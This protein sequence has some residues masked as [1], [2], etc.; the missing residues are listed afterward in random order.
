MRIRVRCFATLRE[1][2]AGLTELELAE[3]ATVAGAWAALADRYPA[4]EPHR[5]FAQ[6]AQNGVAVGWEEPVSDG[7][8]VA[9]LPPVSGGSEPPIIGLSAEP[10]D[11]EALERVVATTHG[12]VVTF[13]G[14]A[15]RLAD[16]GRE[17]TRLEYEAYP[18]M[19][20]ATLREIAA[21]VEK[22][23]P[24]GAVAVVHRVGVV[25]IGEAAVAI[26]TAAPHRGDAYD[27]NRYVIEAIK[28]RLPI[29]KLEHF[30]DGSQ[31]KRPGA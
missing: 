30:P 1:L 14:R 28:A 25:P 22:R 31:W 21:E 13:V 15:R 20:E 2:S 26:V 12:A 6:P 8:E 10:I 3:P 19:A 18:E 17:V 29:W 23:W 7:D 4:L 16:D 24:G 11:V 5:S 27:A 9:F